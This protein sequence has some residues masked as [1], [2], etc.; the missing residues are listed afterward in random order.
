MKKYPFAI[1]IALVG[2]TWLGSMPALQQFEQANV[3]RSHSALMLTDDDDDD[4]DP[5]YSIFRYRLI[6]TKPKP[7]TSELQLANL[8][9]EQTLLARYGQ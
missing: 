9:H 5:G 1:V 3:K 2:A 4:D 8:H 7:E 6:F